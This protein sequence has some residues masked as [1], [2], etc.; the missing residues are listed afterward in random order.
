MLRAESICA[1]DKKK[2]TKDATQKRPTSLAGPKDSVLSILLPVEA[3]RPSRCQRKR[4]AKEAFPVTIEEKQ[5][6]RVQKLSTRDDPPRFRGQT[7]LEKVAVSKPVAID[8][9]RRVME[10][11]A[12]AKKKNF[13][14]NR[15]DNFDLVCCKFVN[16]MFELGFDL[17]DGTKTLAA[18]IDAFPAFPPNSACRGPGEHC[19]DGQNWNHRGHGLQFHGH[20]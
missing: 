7:P 20:S 18:I 13:K 2:S 12:F 19:R 3:N 9:T 11:K 10:L 14:L 16:N 1:K 6:T 8:Y 15:K 5:Q 4:K 17:Q